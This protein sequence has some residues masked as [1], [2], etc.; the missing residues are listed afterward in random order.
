MVSIPVILP[1]HRHMLTHTGGPTVPAIHDRRPG[2]F[3][4]HLDFNHFRTI[5]MRRLVSEGYNNRF[6]TGERLE[7]MLKVRG[8]S[9]RCFHFGS[10]LFRRKLLT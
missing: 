8:S 2:R 4:H 3:V 5:G 1:R 9:S 7:A 6:V 10:T